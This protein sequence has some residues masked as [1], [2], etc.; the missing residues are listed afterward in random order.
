MNRD[1]DVRKFGLPSSVNLIQSSVKF[2][3][4]TSSGFYMKR[5]IELKSVRFQELS[6]DLI[7]PKF[8]VVYT[9]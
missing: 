6:I 2:H 1:K 3:I 5:N 4:E 9:V 7:A 8:T